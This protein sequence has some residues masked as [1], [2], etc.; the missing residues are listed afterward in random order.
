MHVRRSIQPARVEAESTDEVGEFRFH[1]I[2]GACDDIG[3]ILLNDVTSCA[4][5][6]ANA[7]LERA[8]LSSRVDKVRFYK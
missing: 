3:A 7:C 6:D 5:G 2:D 4:P 1:L 8:E